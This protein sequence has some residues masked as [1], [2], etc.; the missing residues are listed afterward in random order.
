[1]KTE[2]RETNYTA[3]TLRRNH[4]LKHDTEGKIGGG[5]EHDEGDVNGYWMNLRKKRNCSSLKEGAL[6]CI[7]SRTPCGRGYGHVARQVQLIN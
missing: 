6:D 1:M 5:R 2:G 4:L 7:L 3:Q